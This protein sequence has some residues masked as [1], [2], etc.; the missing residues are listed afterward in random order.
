MTIEKT[1]KAAGH[2]Q[3]FEPFEVL[4]PAK[5]NLLLRV[6]GRRADGY[7]ELQTLFDILDWGDTLHFSPW[8]DDV[9]DTEANTPPVAITGDFGD[10]PAHENLVWK[11]ALQLLPFARKPVPVQ[12]QITKRIPFGGGLGGGSSD[13]ATALMV[14][15]RLWECGQSGQQLAAMAVALGA[16][17]PVFLGGQAALATGIGEQLIPVELPAR[18]YLLFM[19]EA[20]LSTAEVFADG[21]LPRNNCALSAPDCLRVEN[22]SNDCLAVAT[23]RCPSLAQSWQQVQEAVQAFKEPGISGPHLSGT[24]SVFFVAFDQEP[25]AQRFYREWQ[26]RQR[27]G[28]VD[29]VLCASAKATGQS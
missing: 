25:V 17:V 7:H 8:R 19:P 27:P 4:A 5:I 13:A 6:L 2:F 23:A 24:G 16:D 1:A 26:Q 22:W 18:H 15:N 10:L 29:C 3:D 11:A 9:V 21:R 14:L 20:G 28:L 12:I